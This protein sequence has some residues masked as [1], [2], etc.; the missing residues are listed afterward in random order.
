MN[1]D[2]PLQRRAVFVDRDGTLNVEK[3]YLHRIEDFEFIPGVPEAIHR[4]RNAGFLVI[5]VTN[6]S[7]V[8]RGYFTFAEV[9]VLHRHIQNELKKSGTRIDG[10]YVCPHHPTEGVGEYRRQCDCR[11]GQPGM[12]LRAA[13]ELHVDLT[14]SYM[15]GDKLA[16]VE[17]GERAGCTPLLVMTGYG[18]TEIEKLAGKQ[19]R[20]FADFV[21]ATDY[22]LSTASSH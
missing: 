2:S 10:F 4:L 5:V 9:D 8:A 21:A 6:Q 17:A 1:M 20:C 14:G 15:V 22:V 13:A 3:N 12:L 7:G 19:V 16:D 18:S 11:K